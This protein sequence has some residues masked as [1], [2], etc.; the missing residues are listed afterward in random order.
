MIEQTDILAEH[1]AAVVHPADDPAVVHPADDPDWLDVRR[2]VGPRRRRRWLLVPVAAAVAVIAVGSALGLYPRI[3]DFFTAERAPE[4]VVVQFVIPSRQYEIGHRLDALAWLDAS[5]GELA[6]RS[7]DTKR[8]GI[9]PCDEAAKKE[10]GYG[11]RIC[12]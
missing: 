3:V 7:F 2:R 10:L 6:S 9:Y 1:F 5:G 8:P 12:P 11:V 4:H